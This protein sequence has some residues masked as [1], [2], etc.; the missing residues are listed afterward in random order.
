MPGIKGNQRQLR[1]GVCGIQIIR[2]VCADVS[3]SPW[4]SFNAIHLLVSNRFATSFEVSIPRNIAYAPQSSPEAA[5]RVYVKD[6]L[7]PRST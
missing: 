5:F 2:C 7:F 6:I 3:R 1:A 4:C